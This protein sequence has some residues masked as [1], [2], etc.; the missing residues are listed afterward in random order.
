MQGRGARQ[1]AAG[2][3]C[4][5]MEKERPVR[6]VSESEL[7]LR[8]RREDRQAQKALYDRYAPRM[9]GVCLRY[10]RHRAEAEDLLQDGFIR[11]FDKLRD[12]RMEGSLE[13]WI[14]RIMVRSCINHNRKGAVRNEVPG[15][16]RL[17]DRSVAPV[18]VE[19]LGQQELLALVQAL[20]E[21]YRLVFNLFAVEGYEHA[22]IAELLGCAEGTSRSQ[23]AKARRLLQLW[24]KRMGRLRPADP[25]RNEMNVATVL[26]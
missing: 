18:A 23:L 8:C 13:G 2:K 16:V 24:V 26:K 20:P 12:F 9:F 6:E 3:G 22:E 19:E 5:A 14:R 1:R 15:A 4:L 7:V 21:G 10:A 17:P 11:V 25:I